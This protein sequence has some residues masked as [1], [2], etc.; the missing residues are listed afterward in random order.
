MLLGLAGW[1]LVEIKTQGRPE[2]SRQTAAAD[3]SRQK[4]KITCPAALAFA[5]CFLFGAFCLLL[6]SCRLPTELTD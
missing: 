4:R 2:G 5:V 1:K 3:G 6:P